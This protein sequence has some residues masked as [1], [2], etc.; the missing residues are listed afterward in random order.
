MSNA[1]GKAWGSAWGISW[2]SIDFPSL[3]VYR[4]ILRLQSRVRTLMELES[5]E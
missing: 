4:E 3:K 5:V 2:G 1:W